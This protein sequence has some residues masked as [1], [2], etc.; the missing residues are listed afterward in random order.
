MG[1]VIHCVTDHPPSALLTLSST[2]ITGITTPKRTIMTLKRNR[3]HANDNA[4][5]A[6]LPLDTTQIRPFQR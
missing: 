3:T 4:L 2:A 5:V 6:F 1:T